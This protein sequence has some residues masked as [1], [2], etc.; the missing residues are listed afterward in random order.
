MAEY[1]KIAQEVE[2]FYRSYIDG[3]NR[4]DIDIFMQSFDLPFVVISGEQGAS[5][6]SSEAD[7]QRFY[8]LM[9]SAIQEQGW[10]RS[11]VDQ[12]RVWPLAERLAILLADVTRYRRDGS[13]MAKLRAFY[14]V[15]N[16]GKNWKIVSLSEARAPF[17]GPGD[18]PRPAGG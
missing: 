3:F 9:M 18:L 8:T 4:E 6:C 1:E 15:R 2:A 16:D 7:Q 10:A 12:L 5:V 17:T 13:V 14:N 11:S